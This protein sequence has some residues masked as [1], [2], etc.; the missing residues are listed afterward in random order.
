[1]TQDATKPVICDECGE[2]APHLQTFMW[3]YPRRVKRCPDCHKK[4]E[5]Y[6]RAYGKGTC[7]L[8][9]ALRLNC[10]C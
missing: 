2:E 10:S 6:E 3:E 9:G 5:E 4:K 1:M 8:C 7:G